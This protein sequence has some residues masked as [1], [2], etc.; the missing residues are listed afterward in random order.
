MSLDKDQVRKYII[1]AAKAMKIAMKEDLKGKLV[2]LKFDAATR[3][4]VN[5][6]G[7]NVRYMSNEQS[8]TKTLAVVDTLCE[9]KGKFIN[10]MIQK[11]L[12]EYEIPL[13]NVIMCV[14]DNTK[15]MIGTV[16][17]INRDF[18]AEGGSGDVD[19][20][21]D[22][23]YEDDED[24]DVEPSDLDLE[25]ACLPSCEHMRCA[26]HTLQL[27]IGDGLKHKSIKGIVS[28]LRNVAKEARN[29]NIE[30]IL[31]KTAKKVALI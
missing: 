21:D 22:E 14:T 30:K 2:Y 27:A 15:N 16:K 26:A 11:V 17:D 18:Q 4:R 9:H 12:D 29:P 8:I 7:L 6:L 13:K 20:D 24:E 19:A 1:D 5:Y 3:I 25:A 28:K 31:K 23:D 10:S